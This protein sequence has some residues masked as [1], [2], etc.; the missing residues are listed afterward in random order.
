MRAWRTPWAEVRPA[1]E[2][3]RLLSEPRTLTKTRAWRRSGE[4]STPVTVTNP[5]R[6]SLSSTSASASDSRIAS[7]TRRIRSGIGAHY[8]SLG[9]HELVLLS[10]QIADRLFEQL[11]RLAVL[12]GDAGHGQPGALPEG[13]V[14]DHGHRRAEAVLELRLCRLDVLPLSLQ[15]SSL[16]EVELHGEDPD[17]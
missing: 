14:V 2:L 16:G 11:L 3:T 15:R 10:V 17:V 13:V 7:L 1:S 4:V 8:L 9:A 6:G 12:A 5:M